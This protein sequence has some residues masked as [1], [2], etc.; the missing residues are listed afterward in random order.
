VRDATTIIGLAAAFAVLGYLNIQDF[1][2]YEEHSAAVEQGATEE[3]RAAAL[4]KAMQD[5]QHRIEELKREL[6]R[7]QREYGSPEFVRG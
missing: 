4:K 3:R 2:R 1:H 7:M 5:A 6:E